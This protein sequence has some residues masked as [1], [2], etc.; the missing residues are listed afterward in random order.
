MS[1]TTPRAASPDEHDTVIAAADRPDPTPEPELTASPDAA[2]AEV[3]GNDAP[4]AADVATEPVADAPDAIDE[5]FRTPPAIPDSPEVSPDGA[6]VAYLLP[7][8]EGVWRLW[9]SPVAGGEAVQ[10]ELP[11]TPVPDHDPDSGRTVRGP[12]WSPDGTT[13]ALTGSHPDGNPL[14]TTVWLVP[15]PA[16]AAPAPPADPDAVDEA[17]DADAV[18]ASTMPAETAAAAP[19]EATELLAGEQYEEPT[20]IAEN[21][22]ESGE[23]PDAA[24]LAS[25]PEAA[26]AADGDDAVRLAAPTPL[27]DHP[28]ASDR[29]PRWSPDGMLIAFV[30][31]LDGHDVIALASPEGALP[32][33]AELL[34][35]SASHDREPAWSRDGLFLAF[36]RKRL[37]DVEHN[38]ILVF[39]L[40]TGEIRNL[41]GE[42]TSA[43]RHSLDWVPGRNLVAYVTRENEWLSIAVINSDNKAGWTVTR[44]AGDKVDPRF[45][46]GEPRLVYIRTE[47]FSSVVCERGLHASG[48]TALDPG[49]G[50]GRYPRW[51]ADK[52]VLYGFSAA[53]RPLGFLVQDN[54]ADAE[55]TA[56]ELPGVSPTLG[57]DFRRPSTFEFEVGADAQFS[58]L[59]YRTDGVSGKVPGIVYL[60]DGPLATR[61]AEFLP[62]EQALAR[63]AMAVLTPVLHGATG[64][65]LAI[66]NDLAEL[67]STELEMSDIVESGMALGKVADIDERKLAIVGHGYGGALALL[68]AGGRPGIFSAVAAVD[69]ITDW[70]IELEEAAP[71][72]RTWITR[73][74]GMP[75]TDRD[76]YA[77]R[78]PDTFASVIDVP[79][80]LV[81][82]G[83]SASRTAQFDLFTAFLDEAG[84]SYER[85]E[86]RGVAPSQA[87]AIAGRRLANHFLEGR[88]QVEVVSGIRSEDA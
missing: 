58:G 10:V 59:L 32:V 25:E 45:S 71:A 85:I 24:A 23:D 5:V 62:E 13:I 46:P 37:E 20:A 61:R 17:T 8:A 19:D 75:L 70:A 51:V 48:A 15:V 34:T 81:T 60:P 67:S 44:E 2:V 31:R 68:T 73:Q 82:T 86:A 29:S 26:A 18:D 28:T 21:G 14:R 69:P 36:T 83:V 55:R 78:T 22:G 11:F 30:R 74:Y 49:E 80:V 38:D 84:V 50:V 3:A 54:T 52:R 4:V 53:Q 47:G 88:D 39:I 76:R 12:Q 57:R 66:E 6:R 42:K 9:L 35:W 16:F 40:A 7:D 33:A 64:F 79:L 43:V 87:L 1:D 41:T 63:T 65:G 77:M 27:S 72:W 56:I